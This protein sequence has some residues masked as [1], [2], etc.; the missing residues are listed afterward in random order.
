MTLLVTFPSSRYCFP[1][2]IEGRGLFGEAERRVCESTRCQRSRY[3]SDL[4]NITSIAYHPSCRPELTAM[5]A[6]W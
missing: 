4:T 3:L 5:D 2:S 1:T 6:A